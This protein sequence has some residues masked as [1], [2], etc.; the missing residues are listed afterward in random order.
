VR[1]EEEPVAPHTTA[2]RQSINTS[3]GKRQAAISADL[4]LSSRRQKTRRHK[5]RALHVQHDGHDGEQLPGGRELDPLVQLLPHGQLSVLVLVR[6]REGR[7]FAPVEGHPRALREMPRTHACCEH[8]SMSSG[9]GPYQSMRE[10]CNCPCSRCANAGDKR[11]EDPVVVCVCTST[12][13]RANGGIR[14]QVAL[15]G[16]GGSAGGGRGRT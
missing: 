11:E 9:S 14:Y 7:A 8:N 12:R 5:A 10:I 13:E 4:S 3:I 2:R 1:R 6:A 16:G 15:L